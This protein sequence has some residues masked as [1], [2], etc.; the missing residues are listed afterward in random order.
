MKIPNRNL[1]MLLKNQFMSDQAIEREVECLN[2]IL[3]KTESPEHFCQAH[4]L[5][6]RNRITSKTKRILLAIRFD[7]LKPFRFLISKN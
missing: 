7:K 5:I 4:E 2:E 3:L 6:N 1:L